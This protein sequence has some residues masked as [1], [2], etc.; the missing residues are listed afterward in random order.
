MGRSGTLA[1]TAYAWPALVVCAAAGGLAS[2]AVVTARTLAL[3]LRLRHARY[4]GRDEEAAAPLDAT[5]EH[6]TLRPA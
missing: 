3:A 4:G 1:Q 2:L 6:A 5:G